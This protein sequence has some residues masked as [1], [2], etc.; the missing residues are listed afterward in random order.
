M[1]S[2]GCLLRIGAVM[3]ATFRVRLANGTV[4]TARDAPLPTLQSGAARNGRQESAAP[5]PLL[6]FFHQVICPTG[7]CREFLSS[8]SA[9]NIS[10]FQKPK[11]VV[12]FAPSRTREEGR[13]AIVTDVGSGMRW[14]RRCRETSDTEADGEGVWSWRPDAGVKF[15]RSKLLRDDGGKRARSPGRARISC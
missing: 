2:V 3:R 1:S 8:P 9:K 13:I 15:L 4:G 11:S 14:T 6:A 5:Q 7:S 10:L 12:M